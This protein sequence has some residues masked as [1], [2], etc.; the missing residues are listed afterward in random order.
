MFQSLRSPSLARTAALGAIL[1]ALTTAATA[2]SFLETNGQLVAVSGGPTP[3]LAGATFGGNGAFDTP[4]IDESGS[5]LFRAQFTGGGASG[6]DDRALFYGPAG[7]LQMMTRNGFQAPGMAPGITITAAPVSGGL[8]SLFRLSPGGA[9]A[10]VTSVWNGGTTTSNDT[11][12]Y[13]GTQASPILLARE[14]DPAIGTAGANYSSQFISTLSLNVLSATANGNICFRSLLANGDVVTTPTPNNEAIY[15]YDATSNTTQMLFRKGDPLPGAGGF[16][17]SAVTGPATPYV[18]HMNNSGQVFWEAQINLTI[19]TP[20]P[21]AQD[22]QVLL[23]SSLS[24]GHTLIAREGDAAPGT[25]GDF[26]GASGGISTWAA[27]GSC[28]TPA[29]DILLKSDI[30]GPGTTAAVNDQGLFHK[31]AAGSLALIIRRGDPAPGA[32]GTT[33]NTIT[34][35]SMMLNSNGQYVFTGT[36]AGATTAN[37]GG[38]WYGNTNVP[39]SLALLAREG[40]AAPGTLGASLGNALTVF[41]NDSDMVIVQYTLT[42]GDVSGTTNDQ[43][44]FRWRA[45][46][47]LQLLIRKGETWSQ[48]PGETISSFGFNALP[49]SSGTNLGFS[50]AGRFVVRFGLV[51]TGQA[52]AVID[53]GNT[54]STSFCFG[55]G[56]GTVCPC[57]NNGAAGRGCAN[58]AF[59]NGGQLSSTGIAGASIGTDSLVLTASGIPGPGLFFQGTGQFAGGAGITFG[60]G[61]LCAGGTILRLGVVFPTGNSASYPGGLT[62]APIHIGGATIAGDLR[63][64]QCWY[65]DADITFCSAATY[66]L[67]Q[68]LSL[69]WG[70]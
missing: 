30:K 4:Q 33:L 32:P 1:S 7:G 61:L 60:D 49:D 13:G 58:S 51:S 46:T 31:P 18:L 41:Q 53:A 14:G 66:N 39:G 62:P 15:I 22:N 64:Y 55:D 48:M 37:D 19:G 68:G 8:T 42:G 25:G 57:G 2:Q 12:V 23:L 50:Q 65:R 24:G 16:V 70:P 6:A 20:L 56:T 9:S 47:G 54:P 52:V 59:A 36:L 34:N 45:A 69:T 17:V 38:I 3:G 10:W 67:T 63:H 27:T 11:A 21:T 29:G 40:D 35:S 26:L 43:A 28:F 5:V 44:L